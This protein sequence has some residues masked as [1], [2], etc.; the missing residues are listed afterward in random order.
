MGFPVVTIDTQTGNITQQHFLIHPEAVVDT[1]SDYKYVS[2]G[3]CAIRV[4]S[5]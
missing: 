4:L 5:F 3:K 2:T 1:P